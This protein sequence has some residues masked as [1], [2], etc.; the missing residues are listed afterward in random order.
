LL[1]KAPGIEFVGNIEGRDVMTKAADVIVTDGFTGNVVLKT[2]EGGLRTILTALL[3]A[4]AA[5]EYREHADALLP[6]LMPLYEQVS[7]D[8]YG[9]AMLL[10]VDGVCIISHGSSGEKAVLNAIKVAHEMVSEG[11]VD[12]LRAAVSPS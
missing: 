11:V 4:L 3:T 5:D 1:N 7:P 2:L 10:G 6:A 9:G 8:T 12:D